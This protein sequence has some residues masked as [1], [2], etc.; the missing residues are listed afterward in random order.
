MKKI[1]VLTNFTDQC[2]QVKE[3]AVMLSA[4]LHANLILFNTFI[5]QPAMLSENGSDPWVLEELT[6]IDDSKKKLNFLK[7]DL[8]LLIAALP[9]A[10]H[11]A[12][13][14]C[15]KSMGSLGL[16]VK[17]LLKEEHVEMIVMGARS[18]ST[19]DHILVGSDT[20]SVINH[21]NR[22]VIIVPVGHPLRQL[23]KLT[24]ATD[25]DEA[26][27]N[28]IHYL[29]RLGRLFGFAMEIVHVKL[30][31]KESIDQMQQ[32][33]FEK[34]VAKF[35]FPGISYQNI[36]GKDLVNRLND[37][38]ESN[39]SDVLVLVHDHHSLLHRLL[40]GT[41]AKSLLE[42]QKIPVMIIPAGMDLR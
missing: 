38:C 12:S 2:S 6:W 11:H 37:L 20:L 18:G 29:T 28:A 36:G 8:E 26:D 17:E 14:D 32:T 23:K 24:I 10:D 40:N 7:E 31:G 27:L 35:N 5:S 39:G 1:L 25:F 9:A 30:W 34:H 16:Q 4:K 15:R 21:S 22:P 41:N 33:S 13:I 42:K 19:W 3:T